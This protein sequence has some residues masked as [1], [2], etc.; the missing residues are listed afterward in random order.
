MFFDKHGRRIPPSGLQSPVV[1]ANRNFR[2]SQPKLDYGQLIARA[3]ELLQQGPIMSAADF[4]TRALAIMGH[5]KTN[6]QLANLLKGVH[7]PIVLPQMAVPDY[8]KVLEEIFLT[9]VKKAYTAVFP[10]RLFNNYRKNDL[11]GKVTIVPDTRHEQLIAQMSQGAVVGIYFPTAL[12]GYSI[13]AS[14]EQMVF[15]SENIILSGGLDMAMSMVMYPEVLA[16]D[17]HTPGLD[18]AALQW[19]SADCSLYF[20]ASGSDLYFS[21]RS[22]GADGNSSG[23]L[24]L[25]GPACR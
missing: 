12:Q 22:L 14:R 25:L 18:M 23:G 2:L 6:P 24:L 19:S 3:T 21:H 16:R 5:V 9:A 11:A 7:L 1:D 20:E 10:D 8:G 13:T 15:L 17:F 4:E